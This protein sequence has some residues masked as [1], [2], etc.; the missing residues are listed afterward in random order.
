[1]SV[2][3]VIPMSV[4]SVIDVRNVRDRPR[5]SE[6]ADFQRRGAGRRLRNLAGN[7]ADSRITRVATT[8]SAGGDSAASTQAAINGSNERQSPRLIVSI[9]ESLS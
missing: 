4:M 1:M 9:A 8:A 3:S 5:P 7:H 2:M 6:R